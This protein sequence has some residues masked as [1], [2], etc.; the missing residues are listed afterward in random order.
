[1]ADAVEQAGFPRPTIFSVR[2]D[3]GAHRDA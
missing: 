1:V 2:A 3:G